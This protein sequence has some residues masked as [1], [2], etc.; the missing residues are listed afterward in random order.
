MSTL[1]HNALCISYICGFFSFVCFLILN[2][3]VRLAKLIQT[4]N[5]LHSSRPL[6]STEPSEMCTELL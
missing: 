3:S 5:N 4:E 6:S 1:I 2:I